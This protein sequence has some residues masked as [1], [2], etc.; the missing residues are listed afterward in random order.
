MKKIIS[1]S[2]ICLVCLFAFAGCGV[3]GSRVATGIEFVRDVF[4]VDYNVE[5]RLDYKIYPATADDVY[6]TYEPQPSIDQTSYF[7]FTKD[8][9]I[10]VINK[11][12]TKIDVI[13]RMNDFSDECE[14]RLKEYPTVINFDKTQDYINAG[15]VYALNLSGI[16]NGETRVCGN[17]DFNYKIESSNSSIIEVVSEEAL[18][19]RSTGRR[20]SADIKVSLQ[21]SQGTLMSGL[22]A[23]IKLTVVENISEAFVSFGD[24][25]VVKNG[26]SNIVSMT[27]DEQRLLKVLYFNSLGIQNTLTDFNIYLS[28]EEVFEIIEQDGEVYLKAKHLA[29]T[30]SE[31][32]QVFVTI[33]SEALKVNGEPLKIVCE[34]KVRILG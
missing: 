20:G 27:S 13:I 10:K 21:N 8:G 1:L 23:Q 5:T 11:N 25:L 4:Y 33:Q 15:S 18:L 6:V 26:S 3:K 9:R 24:D 32:Y 29:V 28:N 30:S 16:Y 12:F 7:N 22:E 2:F 34:F 17:G 31:A 14:V 19:V